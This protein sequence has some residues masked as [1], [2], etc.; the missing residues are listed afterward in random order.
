MNDKTMAIF[1]HRMNCKMVTEKSGL[2]ESVCVYV[3]F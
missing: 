3:C 1:T 2:T